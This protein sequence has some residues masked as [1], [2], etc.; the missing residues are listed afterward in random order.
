MDAPHSKINFCGDLESLC[1]NT[2]YPLLLVHG[3]GVRDSKH[4]RIWGRIPEALRAQGATVYLGNHDAWGTP[5]SNAAQLCERLVTIFAESGAEK[6][7]IIAHSKGG[8]DSRFLIAQFPPDELPIASLTTISTPHH[9][10]RSLQF[11]LTH[12]LPVFIPLNALMNTIYGRLGDKNPNFLETCKYLTNTSMEAFNAEQPELPHLLSQQFGS[13]FTKWTDDLSSTG[14]SPL[15]KRIEGP[16]DGLV[17][18]ESAAYDNFCGEFF[19]L[20]GRGISHALQV[21]GLKKPFSQSGIKK[22]SARGEPKKRFARK[23]ALENETG[24]QSIVCTPEGIPL[25]LEDILD[26]Y[27]A[28]VANL[29]TRGF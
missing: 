19:T 7:N 10:S 13:A 20:E 2:R 22:F 5:L 4:E 24:A 17:A 26:L 18:L 23:K 16:N 27:I 15:I 14:T 11:L 6:V 9:G 3:V 21:D 29:K 28:I 8:L 25:E 12:T 1:C